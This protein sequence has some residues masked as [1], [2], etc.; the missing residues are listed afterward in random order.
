M[1]KINTTYFVDELCEIDPNYKSEI[2]TLEEKYKCEISCDIEKHHVLQY[3]YFYEVFFGSKENFFVEIQS[4]INN[5]TE[6]ISSEW[7]VDTKETTKT[8][9]VLKD[10]T[11]NM[12]FYE[13]GSFIAKKAQAVLNTNKSKLFEHHRKNNYD[14]YVT[15]GSSKME[16]DPLLSQLHL[17]AIYEEKEV[18]CNFI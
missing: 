3:T 16:L 14:D 4:G 7:G 12:D 2:K 6:L 8:I 17:E 11:L 1:G 10:F 18:Y 13:K 15:G 9:D 5:G